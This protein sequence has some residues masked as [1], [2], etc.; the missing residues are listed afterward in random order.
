MKIPV[1]FRTSYARADKQILVD[2]GATDNFID[3][4]LI[5]RLGLRSLRLERPRKIWNIDGTN[6]RAGMISDYVDLNVQSGSKGTKMR[7]LVTDLGLEDLILGYPWLAYFEPKF[8]WKEGVIDT[9]HLPVIIR[10]LSWHQTTQTIVSNAT[11][12]R[13]VTNELN[14]QDKDQI[15][16]ELE[17]EYSSGRGMATQF[18]QDAQQYTQMVEVPSEYQRHAKVFDKEASNRF[19]P[20]RPWDHAIE[21]KADAPK[22]IDC[23]VYPITPTEDEALLKFL[24]DMQERGYIRPSKSPYAS[25]FFFIRKK[26]GKLRLVQDYRKLNQWTVPNRYPLPL[27]PELIAQVKDAEI[28]SKFDVRQGYNNVCIKKGDEHKAAFKTKYGLFEP[29][30]MFFGLRNSPSTFQ[31]MMDQEFRDI[32]EE[33]RLL[34]TEIIIYMDDILVASTSLAGHRKA[35]HAILDRLEELDL[36]LKPEKCTWEAPRVDYLG[37]ILE[38][39][40]TRMDPA[41]IKGIANWPTPTTVKQV[42][43]FL[44]F[45]NFYRPFIYHFSH[46]ARPLNE[47]TRKENPWTWEERHQKAFEELR[48]RVTSEPVLAQPRLDQQFE[49]EVD[50]SGFAFGAVLS[51]KG[52]DGKRH[53]IAFYSATALEAERN[54]DIYDLELLA[55]VKACRHWRPYLAGSPHKI[56]VHTDHANLQYWRQPHKISRRIAREVLELSEFDI[57]LHHIPGKNN[58]RA[59]ALSRRPD[60]D[61]GERDNENVIVLPESIFVQSGTTTFEPPRAAQ[62]EDTL[63]PWIDPHQLKKINGEWWKGQ[64]KVITG[65]TEARRNIIKNH[66]DLPAYGH[67]G[68]SRTTDLVAKYHWWPNLAMEVQNYVKGCAECQRHK[69]NTQARKAPL[70]PITPARDALPFQ[71]IAL[72][73]IVKLPISNGYNSILTITDHDCSKAAIFIPCNETIN[74]EGVAGLYLRYVFPRYGLPAKIISDRDPR[75]TSK[76]MKE[77][78]H[79]IGATTNTSTA[80]HPR[81]DGQSERSNQFLGQ[82]LRPWVNAQQDNWEPYL[83]IAEFAHN[84]WRNEMTR[85]TPFSILMGYEPRADISNVPTSIPVLE[86]RREVWKRAREDAHKFIIQAQARWAQSKKEGRTFKEG[87][88]VWLEGRNLHLDQPSAKLAPKRHGPFV[89][90]RVLS[91]ITYQLTLPHQWKIHDVFHVDLLTPYIETDFHGPNYTRPPPD[92]IDGEEEYEVESVLKSRRYGRGRKVQY[93]VKWKGYTDSDNEWVNWD[94]MHA[95]EALAEFKRRWPQAITHIRGAANETESTTHQMST[96]VLCAALPYAELEGPIPYDGPSIAATYNDPDAS[97]TIGSGYSPTETVTFFLLIIV[98]ITD[99][100]WDRHL[101]FVIHSHHAQTMTHTPPSD[102]SILILRLVVLVACDSD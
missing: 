70:S 14:D 22:A 30:V 72:D 76:F 25:S 77:L 41:K 45:C 57:E 26:D 69:I 78:L 40:V 83:P 81:T 18:A 66:H 6:N 64:R 74:A 11:V 101:Y 43:S 67:P 17:R 44:G 23:K 53:P 46:I 98:H 80:Y 50:A 13:I 32:I 9:T 4:R 51:Q 93:L 19:P 54:Y 86:L 39:G 88:Q 61:Q 92:L 15:V 21:L 102:D 28:F 37:L 65:D 49:L 62:D 20:S 96:N 29:L 58:G 71:T 73:F 75:F 3:P 48:N 68:I 12:A 36:Y 34:G 99:Y 97:A 56:I 42:R 16:Q 91:P 24:K 79:L 35:V 100:H 82:F 89:V 47:L 95:D 2:S 8:S 1:S 5:K 90:K 59:D 31:A 94:D 7:F 55:I 38:K 87:D 52:E 27:I 60:Y 33:Q 63:R 84:A 85:Q 10:S